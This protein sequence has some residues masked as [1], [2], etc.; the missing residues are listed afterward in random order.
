MTCGDFCIYFIVHRLFNDDLCLVDLLNEI[1]S[2]ED[3]ANE[4]VVH[5]FVEELREENGKP[6]TK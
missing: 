6:K 5:E 1:F 4:R 2:K 3:V